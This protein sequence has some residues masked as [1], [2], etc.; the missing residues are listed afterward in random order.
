MH[1]LQQAG[2]IAAVVADARD[3]AESPQLAA[4]GFRAVL[5]HPHVGLRRYDGNAIH[6]SDTPITYRRA[7]PLLGQHNRE[8]LTDWL[9]YSEERLE[10]LERDA[11]LADRPPPIL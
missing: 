10:A 9:D 3:I 1:T 6:L 2:I 11:I 8:V 7:A 4:R 5:D